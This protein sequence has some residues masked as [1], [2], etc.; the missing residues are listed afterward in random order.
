MVL[1]QDREIPCFLCQ[2]LRRGRCGEGAIR[3]RRETLIWDEKTAMETDT[4]GKADI[5]VHPNEAVFLE[6]KEV[7]GE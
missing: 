7:F 3:H 2:V 5:N 4:A 1:L 6:V